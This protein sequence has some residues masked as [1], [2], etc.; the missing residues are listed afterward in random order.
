MF[1]FTTAAMVL[2]SIF[3]D[4]GAHPDSIGT[5]LLPDPIV[6]LASGCIGL[7]MGSSLWLWMYLHRRQRVLAAEL[8]VRSR[9]LALAHEETLRT[10]ALLQGVIDTLPMAIWAVDASGQ[11][12][13]QNRFSISAIG[14]HRGHRLTELPLALQ[15]I[16]PWQDAIVPGLQGQAAVHE[17]WHDLGSGDPRRMQVRIAPVQLNTSLIA[18]VGAHFD[19]TERFRNDEIP[20]ATQ[21]MATLGELTRDITH[22]FNNLLAGI[23]GYADLI[24]FRSR[25]EQAHTYAAKICATVSQAQTLTARI[26][27]FARRDAVRRDFYDA[28]GVISAAIDLFTATNPHLVVIS[29]LSAE[30]F[31][32]RGFADLLENAILNLCLNARDALPSGGQVHIAS[33]VCAVDAATASSLRPYAAK[34]GEFLHITV[35]DTGLGM[36]PEVIARCLEP[37]FTTKGEKGTGLGLANVH[38]CVLDHQGALRID[39]APNQGTTVHLWLPLSEKRLPLKPLSETPPDLAGPD[40]IRPS[41]QLALERPANQTVRGITCA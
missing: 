25:D 8:E 33:T 31:Q 39:T 34:P 11:L 40:I 17:H 23:R 1:D 29:S 30:R 28:H 7:L 21:R 12:I 5:A 19:I 27:G 38:A 36:I 24:T 9:Q 32:V 10:Q 15:I 26:L 16:Q 41:P 14:D 4:S 6:F 20:R 18:V 2:W 13:L 37:L 22:D 35:C 3:S